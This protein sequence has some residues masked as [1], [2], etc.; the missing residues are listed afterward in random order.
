MVG[1]YPWFFE[2]LTWLIPI[3]TAVS[4]RETVKVIVSSYRG[5]ST[6][7]MI[8]LGSFKSLK[9]LDPIGSAIA[10]LILV[11]RHKGFVY[12]WARG[13]D[14][15]VNF[16]NRGKIDVILVILSGLLFNYIMAI[17][18]A[19]IGKLSFFLEASYQSIA[20]VL[21]VSAKNGIQINLILV[22]MHLLPLPPLDMSYLIRSFLPRYIKALYISL[23]HV[24][25]YVIFVLIF[26]RIAK[27]ILEP[28]YIFVAQH[29]F[30]VLG[31]TI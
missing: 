13:S 21:L 24:G 23:D 15:R 18:W 19:Y 22:I 16:L 7:S 1:A 31:F 25:H 9:N 2:L 17:T 11:L 28:S 10:P 5:D 30:S 4:W 26:F 29:M 3:I 27:P 12:A 6:A 14:L 8:G 20:K